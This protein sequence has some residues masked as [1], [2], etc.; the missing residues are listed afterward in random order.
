[1]ISLC[2]PLQASLPTALALGSFDGLHA[3]HQ[4]VI[5]RITT[6]KLGIP[7]VVSF[8]PHPR[9]VLYGESRLRLDLPSEKAALLEPLGVKQLVLVPFDRLLASL[10]AEEF[11]EQILLNQLQ[12]K[13]IA[14]G[15]NFRFGKDREGDNS[16]LIKLGKRSNVEIIVVEIIEDS[17]GRMSSSR[18]R[19][20]LKAG[21]LKTTNNLLGRPYVFRGAVVQGKGIG[22]EIGWPTANLQVDARKLL[23]S[24]GV[25]AV[26]AKEVNNE[27]FI[28]AVMNLGSQPTI[29]PRAPSATEVHFLNQ[30]I[31]L[32]GKELI[33]KPVER[34]RD[35]KKF[36]TLDDLS[37]QIKLDAKMAIS[38]LT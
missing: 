14:I 19:S 38:I 37:N 1:M 28:P 33:V 13:Q 2:S 21:D 32:K 11:F 34:I 15:A 5:K 12:A 24:P 4:S 29:D 25:Y 10:T 27:D 3:G 36:P 17:K 18:I 20:A 35:Q 31:D 30:N 26:L 23:P 7:T 22:K 16:T 6:T 9:E 8:W